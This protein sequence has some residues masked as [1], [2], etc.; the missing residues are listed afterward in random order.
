MAGNRKTVDTDS[1]YV[2]ELFARTALNQRIPSGQ[3]LISNGDNSTR[4][5]Y[6]QPST[7]HTVTLGGVA[8][9][10]DNNLSTLLISTSG[11]LINTYADLSAQTLMIQSVPPTLGF[12]YAPSVDASAIIIPSNINNYSS[13]KFIG[14][15]DIL[16]ST[17]SSA[18]STPAVFISISSFTSANYSS[19]SGE[20]YSWRPYIYSVLSTAQTLPTFVS[21]IPT[22]WPTGIQ[23]LSTAEAYPNFSNGDT[24]FS[25]VSINM[26]NYIGYIQP[27]ATKVILEVQPTYLLPSFYLGNEAYP[28]LLKSISSYIQYRGNVSTFI[29]SDSQNTD[30]ITSQQLS[31]SNYFNKPIKLP[32][33]S[34]VIT[35]NWIVDGASGYYTLYHRIPGGMAN[36]NPGGPCGCHTIGYRGGM[37]MERPT[38]VN[39][40]SAAFM[41][42]YN[43]IPILS[44]AQEIAILNQRSPAPSGLIIEATT[45]TTALIS[46]TGAVGAVSY[47]FKLDN[48]LT[49]AT[50]SGSSANFIGLSPGVI[51]ALV[52]IAVSNTGAQTPSGLI[53]VTTAPIEPRNM[54][55]S[56]VTISGFTVTWYNFTGATSYTYTIN[57]N[58]AAPLYET[59]NS[60]TFSGLQPSGNYSIDITSVNAGGT[61]TATQGVLAITKPAAAFGFTSVQG[62]TTIL[63]NWQ[64]AAGVTS[65]SFLLNGAPAFPS[66]PSGY[67]ANFSGL[68]PHTQYNIV[69]IVNGAGGST[70]SNTYSVATV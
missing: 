45:Q 9:N 5:D 41:G 52:V 14:V 57:D 13:V 59:E 44:T 10:A 49:S 27:G 39:M 48:V 25:S 16:L 1:I 37:N 8:L 28:T 34:G 23:N 55:V 31:G 33:D 50:V 66:L 68:I 36:L 4:W 2:R 3:V 32:I 65:Y 62:T 67:S 26:S 18:A 43:T 64:G 61:A 51:Y 69:V 24:Y 12:S 54:V 22:C 35:S 7:F 58:P 60:A 17:V 30:T 11:T 15:G 42:I 47:L 29:I 19:I 20:A 63:L 56:G 38:Y 21:T 40:T 53:Y 70:P 46:W 6:L